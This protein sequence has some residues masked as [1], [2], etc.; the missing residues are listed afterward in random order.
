VT[1]TGNAQSNTITGGVGADTLSGGN[2]SVADALVGGAG[3][4]TYQL[5]DALDT[6]TEVAGATG[7]DTIKLM[8]A[9]T[10][11]MAAQVENLVLDASVTSGAALTGNASSNSI[12]GGMGN[13]TL[14]GGNDT[15]ADTLTGGAGSDTYLL[16]DW[17]DTISEQAGGTDTD[18]VR[19]MASTA[20]G[21]ATQTWTVATGVEN[22]QVDAAITNA[23]SL[24]GNDRNNTFTGSSGKD[25]LSGGV[26][27]DTLLGNGG[28]DS[29]VGGAGND[30]YQGG[31]GNDT[32]TDTDTVSGDTYVWGLAQ[33]T[34]TLTDAGGSADKLTITGV[35]AEQV[36]FRHISLTKN[37]EISLIGASADKI[38]IANWFNGTTLS[39]GLGA[40]ALETLTL[41]NGNA[42]DITLS[43]SR[44]QALVSAM[45][46]MTI[47]AP[48][49][50]GSLTTPQRSA[51]SNNWF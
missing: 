32:L 28:V 13:D 29:L 10:L 16:Y 35:V 50:T 30:Y 24:T 21:T 23:F 22:V 8:K 34:D 3:G 26:G 18:T 48:A 51:I 27:D 6:I 17:K 9:A 1:L 4:D 38:V 39:A 15:V 5:Y 12:T 43:A 40:G 37:L 11:T 2:D 31:A 14:W 42:S 46:S 36:W 45:G 44:V 47:A 7:T 19:I 41:A 33:G 49:S 20:W 25:T